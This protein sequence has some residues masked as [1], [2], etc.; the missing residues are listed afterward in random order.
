MPYK[1]AEKQRAAQRAYQERKRR[2]AGVAPRQ[3]GEDAE[4]KKARANRHTANRPELR[5]QTRLKSKYGLSLEQFEEMAKNGCY[6]CGATDDLCVDHCHDTGRV[7]GILCRKHNFAI[8][9]LGDTPE[10]VQKAL[11]YLWA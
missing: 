6:L 2:A 3:V 7:R 5:R 4:K 10:G 9:L 11:D 1:D 8:G